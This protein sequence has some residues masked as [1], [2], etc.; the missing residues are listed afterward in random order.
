MTATKVFQQFYTKLVEA[1]PVDDHGFMAKLC[2]YNVID[3]NMKFKIAVDGTTRQSK[4]TRFLDNCIYPGIDTGNHWKFDKLLSVMEEESKYEEL[5]Q[6]AQLIRTSLRKRP[7]KEHGKCL[8]NLIDLFYICVYCF[9]KCI[10]L[11]DLVYTKLFS[12]T[13]YQELFTLLKP[14]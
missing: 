1:L 12:I 7:R 10:A 14:L 9:A 11:L 4:A 5:I 6:L 8:F 3:N 13:N 2:S